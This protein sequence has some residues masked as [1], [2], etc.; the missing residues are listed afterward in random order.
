MLTVDK[1]SLSYD[2]NEVLKDL[3]FEVP[4]GKVVGLVGPNGAGKTSLLKAI[5]NLIPLLNGR[6]FFNEEDITDMAT[7]KIVRKG[8]SMTFQLV[9]IFP[10]MTVLDNV[11]SCMPEGK[12]DGFFQA[13]LNSKTLK[14]QE[15]L[16][17]EK[18]LRLLKKVGLN[19]KADD[20]AGTL[21]FGQKRR[22]DI[23][24]LMSSEPSL[25]LLDEPTSGLDQGAIEDILNIIREVKNE[26]RT[27]LLVEHNIDA[28]R[29]IC[30]E[31]IVLNFGEI[32][33][34]GTPEKVLDDPKVIEA[35]I[36][37]N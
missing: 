24:R 16:N 11:L 4:Q 1:I 2:G 6:I 17:R 23:A 22:L 3:S 12:G 5:L 31:V 10:Q 25:L 34:Q 9:K 37:G 27:I 28:V 26:G 14:E 18:G 36:G 15:R 33:A 8:I 35:Y 32:I 13:L 20:W 29:S 7:Y 21:S 19:S 30:D